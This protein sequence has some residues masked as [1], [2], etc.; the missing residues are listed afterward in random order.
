MKKLREKIIIG[1]FFAA[2][3]SMSAANAFVIDTKLAEAN[4]NSGDAAELAWIRS[5]T[6][7]NSLTLD[8]KIDSGSTGFNFVSNGPDSW[9]IDVD[10]DTPGFF[11]L[12]FG[13]GG[14]GATA[15]HFAFQ[16]TAELTKLVW[17]NDQVQFLTGGDC[18]ANNSNAC[19]IGRLSHYV[20]SSGGGGGTNQVPEPVSLLLLGV[21]F[22]GLAYTRRRTS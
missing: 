10:P 20:G 18:G 17:S 14:T 19:N 2:T 3:L 1:L 6:G 5:V 4:I 7:D 13:T 8:F 15:D 11:M 9:Y 22:V 21:G 12:K 16:N